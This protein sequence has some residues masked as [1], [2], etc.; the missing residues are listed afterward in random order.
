MPVSG[1]SLQT[2]AISA[3]PDAMQPRGRGEHRF[4]SRLIVLILF[5]LAVSTLPALA[6][7]NGSD[8]PLAAPAPATA[9][10]PTPET[11]L[12]HGLVRPGNLVVTGF[13]GTRL[14]NPGIEGARADADAVTIETNGAALRVLDVSGVGAASANPATDATEVAAYPARSIGQV[15]GVALDDATDPA[16]KVPAP[17][18]YATATAA[19]GLNIVLPPI[20]DG[21]WPRRTLAGDPAA[22]W[23]DGQWGIGLG[24]DGK[25]VTGGPGS[26][27]RIDGVT[28]QVTLFATIATGGRP[29]GAASLG[30]IAYDATSHQ[31]F[32]SDLESGLIHRLSLAA[33]DLGSFDH[34]LTAR[35]ASQLA[36]VPDDPSTSADITSIHFRADDPNTW[37]FAQPSRRV[38]GLN[39]SAGRLYYA[40]ADGPEVW[41]VAIRPDGD[42]GDARREIVVP[43]DQGP[44]EITDVSFDSRGWIYLAQRPPVTG[45]DDYLMLTAQ[46]PAKLLRYRPDPATNSWTEVPDEYRVGLTADRRQSDGGVALGYGYASDGKIDFGTCDGTLWATGDDLDRS[47][48]RTARA[49]ASDAPDGSVGLN[50]SGLQGSPTDPA[51]LTPQALRFADYD[52]L[53]P[54]S[55]TR[56]QIGDVRVFKTCGS[57]AASASGTVVETD[58][59]NTAIDLDIEKIARGPCRVDGI[60]HIELRIWNRGTAR[61]SGPLTIADRLEKAGARLVDTA[62]SRWQCGQGG[63]DI[64]CRH[65]AVEI[66]P[67]FTTSLFLDFRLPRGWP[68]A[69]FA[70]CA[71]VVWFDDLTA[72]ETI[73]AV[74]IELARLRI[75]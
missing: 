64:S 61:Y 7:T 14:A 63:S 73:V 42:F 3:A 60:C 35:R 47:P 6:Q 46:A 51:V 15:F 5:G 66:R 56:G 49:G 72:P 28:G 62:P 17:N 23:M 41:S 45:T 16:T 19:Y 52:G 4:L 2:T 9:P 10:A 33:V 37:G 8:A 65:P 22:R 57:P 36:D 29:T 32:V 74:E 44:F 71:D 21:G 50:V 70:D 27:W 30:A 69:Q 40:V 24:A 31:F 75:F 25:P 26:V 54:T 20:D 53:L 48:R 34:G 38:W 13:S 55:P 68:Y 1:V 11:N 59:G 39:V 67:G 58:T 12:P 43:A 18:I